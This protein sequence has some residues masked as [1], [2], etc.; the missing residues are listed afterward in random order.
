MNRRKR[1]VFGYEL[2]INM[3]RCNR[4]VTGSRKR[5]DAWGT[6]LCKE[7]KMER[8]GP[9]VIDH[10]GKGR[11]AG[12]TAYLRI[13]TSDLRVHAVDR[14]GSAYVNIFSC[15]PFSVKKAL[16]YTVQ[17]FGA[18]RVSWCVLERSEPRGRRLSLRGAR[19]LCSAPS[20]RPRA[21][22]YAARKSL[23][24]GPRG[25]PAW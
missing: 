3:G 6:G 7:I 1:R 10:F 4:K 2:V 11:L 8:Y 14:R 22:G 16:R 13:T 9:P 17:A 20:L 21:G 15:K 12:W 24:T 25:T 19:R 5:I 23:T 18:K